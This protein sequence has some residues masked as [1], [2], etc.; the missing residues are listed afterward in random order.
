MLPGY[1]CLQR[2][3]HPWKQQVAK[4]AQ[5]GP[6]QGGKRGRQRRTGQ[7][8]KRENQ[9]SKQCSEGSV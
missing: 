2:A 9:V 1:C 8:R 7:A 6:R 5:A 4:W 3:Q